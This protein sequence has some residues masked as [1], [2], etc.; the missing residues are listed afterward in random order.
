LKE[1]TASPPAGNL[2]AQQTRFNRF[3]HI[4]NRE[5]PHEALRMETPDS[6]YRPSP[7]PFSETPEPVEYPGHFELRRVSG[8][9]TLRWKNRKVFVSSLL[10]RK[11]VAL[12]QISDRAWAVY[13]GPVRLGWLHEDDFRIMDV[14]E[15][16][17]RCR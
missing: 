7:R 3:R 15:P 17:R 11:V 9:N 5:R 8:D 14:L 6:V 1:K 2:R 13:F 4:Y 10:K 12:E 16:E